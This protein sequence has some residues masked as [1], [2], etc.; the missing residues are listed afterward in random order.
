M[1]K[2][3][4][5]VLY[6]SPAIYLAI[7]LA[8]YYFLFYRKGKGFIQFVKYT[9]APATF[10]GGIIVYYVGYAET[11]LFDHPVTNLLKAFFSASRFFIL[12]NDLIEIK[13]TVRESP[14]FMLW[15][16]IIAASAAVI[17]SSLLI[18]IFGT[19]L[20]MWIKIKLSHPEKVYVFFGVNEASITLARDIRS[21]STSGFILFIKNLD[22]HES[23]SLYK[24]IEEMGAFLVGG[25]S[26]IDNLFVKNE[27]SIVHTNMEAQPEMRKITIRENY[28]E[29]FNLSKKVTSCRTHFL[30]LS[31]NEDVN[32][33]IT[34][35][36]INELG[37]SKS[38]LQ[39]EIT[40]HILT[41]SAELDDIFFD[42][43]I[44]SF[45]ITIRLL[46]YSYLASRDLLTNYKPVEHVDRD[47]NKGIATS[48]FTCM[49]IGFGQMGIAAFKVLLEQG[50]FVG[51]R[52]KAIAIDKAMNTI[53]GTFKNRYPGLSTN[54]EIE[55][56]ELS[57][58][59]NGFYEII[60]NQLN[61]LNCI[62]IT[63][64]SDALNIQTAFDIQQL[65][66][67][68]STKEIEILVQ[69]KDS[70][71]YDNLLPSGDK[72]II[73]L[74]GREIKVFTEDIVIGEILEKQAKAVHDYYN[75][76]NP[77]DQFRAWS[78]LLRIEQ[79]SNISVAEHIDTLL[80]LIG[81]EKK[82]VRNFE[83]EEQFIKKLNPETL[84]NL[85]KTEH[86]RWNVH[87]FLN[88]WDTLEIADIPE[89]AINNK[90]K[91]RK[92]HACLVSWEDLALINK[93]FIGKDFYE[94]DR[95]VVKRTYNLI[96]DWL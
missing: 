59:S 34:R 38:L 92:L 77:P 24:Q 36:V 23:D 16:A 18:N 60:K 21:K 49:V 13:E 50:Q 95:E 80:Y 33:R 48:D 87:Q 14:Y 45:R 58:G 39:K 12:G 96:K 46:N 15:F 83:T 4:L 57:A 78:H 82:D 56:H 54:Y 6:F 86:L 67:R 27:E 29:K 84:E 44:P 93:K 69:V 17:F 30:L 90:I 81:L 52:F 89:N 75:A 42:S 31:E 3:Y 40:F 74:F 7:L 10:V 88:G 63:L 47:I 68:L 5:D 2:Y 79:L 91:D 35:S 26:L 70:F 94:Y 9:L 43:L 41:L 32:I 53:E 25:E 20:L 1:N 65:V 28:L 62:V 51:S 61:E 37:N 71:A 76:Q 73:R 64:G 66:K 85:A 8:T 72:G 22:A 19:N 55:F 11:N